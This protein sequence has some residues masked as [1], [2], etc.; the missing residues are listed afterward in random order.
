[1][2]KKLEV[3][4][5]GHEYHNAEVKRFEEM[6]LFSIMEGKISEAIIC[7]KMLTKFS[8]NV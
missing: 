6:M 8:N 3:L 7:Y 2:N 5:T 1:M 4:F